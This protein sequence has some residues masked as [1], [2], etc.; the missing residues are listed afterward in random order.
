MSEECRKSY[1]CNAE[2]GHAGLC[3]HTDRATGTTI[4]F[5]EQAIIFDEDD[6]DDD[7]DTDDS[8]DTLV[9]PSP[10]ENE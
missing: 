3:S 7:D 1:K 9:K 4:I 6:D 5:D 10:T 2:D 8:D